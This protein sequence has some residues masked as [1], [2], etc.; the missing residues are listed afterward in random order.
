MRLG[1]R[2]VMPGRQEFEGYVVSSTRSSDLFLEIG[3]PTFGGVMVRAP[4]GVRWI[5]LGQ[6]LE[7]AQNL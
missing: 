5:Q 6:I 2:W 7:H 3:N 4:I 1:E